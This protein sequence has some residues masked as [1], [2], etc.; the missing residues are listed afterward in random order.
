LAP[1]EPDALSRRERELLDIVYAHGSATANEVRAAMPDAPT[2]S[3]VRGLLRVL[4]EKGHLRVHKDG[5]RNV[6]VPTKKKSAAGRR[7]LQRAVET[8]FGGEVR[9]A[10]AALLDL[11]PGELTARERSRLLKL[12]DKARKEGR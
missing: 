2:Y 10:V 12:I 3:G 9:D 7:A 5:V 4:V 6:Y 1:I 11:A 8:F